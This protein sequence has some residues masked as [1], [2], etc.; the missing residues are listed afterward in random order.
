[1]SGNGNNIDDANVEDEDS[2][3]ETKKDNASS[4]SLENYLPASA[5]HCESTTL[6]R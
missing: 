4:E 5:T 2:G 6:Y 1:M 3:E